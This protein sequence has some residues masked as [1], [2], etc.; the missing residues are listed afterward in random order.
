MNNQQMTLTEIIRER[1]KLVREA[2]SK[3]QAY[4]YYMKFDGNNAKELGEYITAKKAV[5]EFDAQNFV[6]VD[7]E[8]TENVEALWTEKFV[9]K[10][11]KWMYAFRFVPGR[12]QFTLKRQSTVNT[13]EGYW[14]DRREEFI[15]SIE[16][17]TAFDDEGHAWRV[18]RGHLTPAPFRLEMPD[19]FKVAERLMF[20][21]G[22]Y[23]S[24]C[25]AIVGPGQIRTVLMVEP[26]RRKKFCVG[27]PADS[28]NSALGSLPEYDT[29]YEAVEAAVAWVNS[30][31]D[32]YTFEAFK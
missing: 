5:E 18:L 29:L 30:A 2:D 27:L 26:I 28:Y 23:V 10:D 15:K 12:N 21:A 25:I 4:Y 22:N 24:V 17:S 8:G 7:D 20:Q 9:H 13:T 19:M 31:P 16:E 11:E 1:D 14:C 6:V 3:E 32:G